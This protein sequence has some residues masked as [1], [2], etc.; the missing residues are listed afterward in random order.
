MAV[1]AKNNTEYT[2]L[3]S[4]KTTLIGQIGHITR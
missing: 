3:E 4:L 2:A 1:W